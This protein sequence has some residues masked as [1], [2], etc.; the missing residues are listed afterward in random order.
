MSKMRFGKTSALLKC[1][2]SVCQY[3]TPQILHF[4]L[5]KLMVTF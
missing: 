4:G 5:I 2:P 1:T 3:F